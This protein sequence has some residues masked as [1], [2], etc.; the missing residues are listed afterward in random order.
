MLGSVLIWGRS[1]PLHVASQAAL[2]SERCILLQLPTAFCAL[3]VSKRRTLGYAH[4]EYGR[5]GEREMFERLREAWFSGHHLVRD[6]VGTVAPLTAFVALVITSYPA[7]QGVAHRFFIEYITALSFWAF[8]LAVI[9]YLLGS[10]FI[11][12][13]V[14]FTA[15][16]FHRAVQHVPLIGRKCSYQFWY[17]QNAADIETA[18]SRYFH[19]NTWLS[20]GAAVS[21]TD[22]I[23]VLKLYFQK[24][25]PQ[26]YAEAY[27]QFMK[28]DLV[29]AALLYPAAL[30]AHECYV[31]VVR[32]QDVNIHVVAVSA[33][34]LTAA[35][36]ELPRR[37]RKVVRTEYLFILASERILMDA[38]APGAEQQDGIP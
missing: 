2:E 10:Y 12:S 19:Y 7:V 17:N 14:A 20:S 1:P 22:K 34:I 35:F 5:S 4:A 13:L 18:Y 33:V 26:G 6:L 36:F 24:Y 21:P 29:R 30:I 32:H 31:G 8:V 9:V 16:L 28:V 27:R 11:G 23:N 38:S 15:N 3:D 25:N 37:I